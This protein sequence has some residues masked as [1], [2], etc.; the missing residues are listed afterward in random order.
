MNFLKTLAGCALVLAA[1][2]AQTPGTP[3]AHATAPGWIEV[4]ASVTGNPHHP[5]DILHLDWGVQN[6]STSTQ[7]IVWGGVIR[8]ADGSNL[9]VQPRE[10]EV[11]LSG[12]GVIKFGS[13]LLPSNAPLGTATFHVAAAVRGPLGSLQGPRIVHAS[14]SFDI[15]P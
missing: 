7:Q 9:V 14:E 5:G 4:F 15:V 2:A 3:D 1:S 10:Q 11:L 6:F 8:Y 12:D 13:F